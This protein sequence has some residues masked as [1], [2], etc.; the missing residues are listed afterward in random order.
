MV[1]WFR[2]NLL[3]S[4][5]FP[6]V[7]GIK[8]PTISQFMLHTSKL[9]LTYFCIFVMRIYVL[10]LILFPIGS[11]SL[12]MFLKWLFCTCCFETDIFDYLSEYK[13]QFEQIRL[14]R[15]KKW[16]LKIFTH[17]L[18]LNETVCTFVKKSQKKICIENLKELPF[19]V[20]T[21]YSFP[22]Q[23]YTEIFL[24]LFMASIW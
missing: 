1:I 20:S 2:T 10:L 15:W 19:W 12:P 23:S 11:L 4:N 7:C 17:L 21:C 3:T 6:I 14:F 22:F 18:S 9:F 8:I 24:D 13:I 5:P 16:I